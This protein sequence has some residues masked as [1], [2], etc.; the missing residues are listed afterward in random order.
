MRPSLLVVALSLASIVLVAP[1]LGRS[2]PPPSEVDRTRYAFVP[3]GANVRLLDAS[4]DAPSG[5]ER[6]PLEPHGFGEFLRGLP[7]RAA[8][9]AVLSFDGAT[10]VPANDPRVF[11][12]AELDVGRADLQQCADS[13]IRLHA[14]WLWSRNEAHRAAYRFVSGDLATF[15]GYA[16]GDRPIVQG[17]RVTWARRAKP[18]SDRRAYRSFLD[19]VFMYA[20]TI[21]LARDADPVERA[22]I[23]PGDMFV[24]P[25][26]PGHAVVVLDVAL[27]PRGRRVALLGQGYMPA[28]DFHVLASREPGISPWFSLE[29]DAVETPFWP[30][31]FGWSTLRRFKSV[32]PSK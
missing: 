5:F 7:L 13:A 8:G 12:V 11:A 9:S 24:A 4:I 22:A 21:S 10:V 23:L 32:E 26:G 15:A 18:Q 2:E 31:P 6:V 25:G 17:N 14:E 20:S 1:R 30:K 16:A 28:Q 29:V 3:E 19:M 27:D